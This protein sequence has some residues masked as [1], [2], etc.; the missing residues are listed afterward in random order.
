[1]SHASSQ[2][3]SLVYLFVKKD[4]NC[5]LNRVLLVDVTRC[6]QWR[7]QQAATLSHKEGGWC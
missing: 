3:Y 2:K 6:E 5:L 4:I 1:M 7:H